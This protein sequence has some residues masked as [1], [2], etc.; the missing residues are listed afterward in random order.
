M[1]EEHSIDRMS[2]AQKEEHKRSKRAVRTRKKEVF[3]FISGPLGGQSIK[4]RD[5]TTGILSKMKRFLVPEP[6]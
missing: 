4:W 1:P 3:S 6:P 2:Q 5:H